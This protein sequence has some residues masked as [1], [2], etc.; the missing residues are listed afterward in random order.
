MKYFVVE[1]TF[2]ENV[3]VEESEMQ[4]AIQAHLAF[5]QKGF[6]EGFILVSGP[7]VDVGGGIIVIKGQSLQDVEDYFSKD[8]LQTSGIQEYKIVEFELY[9]CQA[10]LKEW[11]D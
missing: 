1:G 7:K 5:L 6:D 10:F 8:P 9:D 11:F 3:P 2:R 4:K